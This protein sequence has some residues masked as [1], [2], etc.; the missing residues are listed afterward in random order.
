MI[1]PLA[2]LSA[3]V[4]G[5]ISTAAAG[6]SQSP[7]VATPDNAASFIGDWTLSAQGDQG[8]AQFGLS[9]KVEEG[10]VVGSIAMGQQAGL[11]I[12]DITLSGKTLVLRYDFDYQGM[13]IDA[14]VSLTPGGDKVALQVAF[15]GGAYSMSG[16]AEKKK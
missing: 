11:P 16:T 9:I 6:L 10:K 14:V 4:I 13:P 15:A 12:T 3:V 7:A 1:R 8:P 5:L 2:L